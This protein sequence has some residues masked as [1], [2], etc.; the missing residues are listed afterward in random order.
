M[1]TPASRVNVDSAAPD[2]AHRVIND[3]NSQ[4]TRLQEQVNGLRLS[5]VTV[6][7]LPAATET[8]K[9]ESY[10][11]ADATVTTFWTTVV[12]GGA[13]IIRVTSDGTAWKIG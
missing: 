1:T 2:W 6:A 3:L 11:V 7:D 9:G 8:N 4:V 5:A 13:N 10:V 12:G